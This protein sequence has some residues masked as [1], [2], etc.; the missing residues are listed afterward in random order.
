MEGFSMLRAITGQDHIDQVYEKLERTCLLTL[1]EVNMTYYKRI[2]ESLVRVNRFTPHV[3]AR[4]ENHVTNNLSMEYELTTILDILFAFAASGNGTKE[5]YNALQ[6][7]MVKGHMFNR[8]APF[9]M[10]WNDTPNHGAFVA[11]LVHTYSIVKG[12]HPELQFEPDFSALAYRLSTS[13]RIK[14]NLE[15]LVTVMEHIEVFQYED[16]EEVNKVLDKKLFAIEEN[17]YA[18]DMIKYIDTKVRRD[19]GGDYTKLPKNIVTFFDNYMVKNLESQGPGRVYYYLAESEVRGLLEGKEE[20]VY[21]IVREAGKKIQ[22]YDFEKVCY[23]YWFATK[24]GFM[25]EDK[26]DLKPT[27]DLFKDYIRLYRVMGKDKME[28]GGNYYKMLEVFNESDLS[29][30][31]QTVEQK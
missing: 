26:T 17:M 25:I 24:Y 19:Y 7:V 28:L 11:K 4:I 21:K 9:Q 16:L 18:D 12:R 20:L 14:Y 5:F 13:D 27:L 23:I 8:M 6:F 2:A 10:L 29:K 30:K 1:W 3:F 31:E 22:Q 15:E